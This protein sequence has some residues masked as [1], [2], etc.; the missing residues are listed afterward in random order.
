M[1]HSW[2]LVRWKDKIKTRFGIPFTMTATTIQEPSIL[3]QLE[4]DQ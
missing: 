3:A 2:F 1:L 4:S